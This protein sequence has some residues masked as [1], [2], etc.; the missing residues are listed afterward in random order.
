MV[1]HFGIETTGIVLRLSLG[2]T[3][4]G[5][6]F[7]GANG[8]VRPQ[9]VAAPHPRRGTLPGGVGD[10]EE[11]PAPP[12][13]VLGCFPAQQP[14]LPGG[15]YPHDWHVWGLVVVVFF[16]PHT[17]FPASS[18]KDFTQ[19]STKRYVG[20]QVVKID[21]ECLNPQVPKFL[22]FSLFLTAIEQFLR[23]FSLV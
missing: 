7:W 21:I 17:L 20:P 6:K 14:L 12:A 23:P 15:T 19:V 3:P 8:G 11:S 16:F 9:G 1:W 2:S 4:W 18:L 13:R 10:A 5:V 22:L